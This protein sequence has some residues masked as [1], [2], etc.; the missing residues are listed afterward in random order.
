MLRARER[1]RNHIFF[2]FWG[3]R[4]RLSHRTYLDA[5]NTQDSLEPYQLSFLFFWPIVISP[6][7]LPPW[8]HTTPHGPYLPGWPVPNFYENIL[9]QSRTSARRWVG[10]GLEGRIA[11][12]PPFFFSLSS[13]IFLPLKQTRLGGSDPNTPPLPFFFFS[14]FI[15]RGGLLGEW[16]VVRF[17]FL[18]GCRCRYSMYNATVTL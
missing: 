10:G 5:R 9:E 1:E 12:T 17:R 13:G 18:I 4:G 16:K 11:S 3:G 6:F 15:C 8:F 14:F 2:L 7:F